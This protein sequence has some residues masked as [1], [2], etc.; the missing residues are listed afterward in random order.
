M[1]QSRSKTTGRFEGLSRNELWQRY[2]EL[3]DKADK[4]LQNRGDEMYVEKMNR[5]EFMHELVKASNDGEKIGVQYVKDLVADQEYI[6]SRRSARASASAYREYTSQHPEFVEE[7]EALDEN[8][9]GRGGKIQS[10]QFRRGLF[11]EDDPRAQAWF[12]ML[13][14]EYYA[15]RGSGLKSKEARSIISSRF[16]GSPT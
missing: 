16:Y 9:K 4:K 14:D 3:Y 7:I 12:S 5:D 2:E 11:D 15:L 13:S 1:K 6:V 10:W 8:L